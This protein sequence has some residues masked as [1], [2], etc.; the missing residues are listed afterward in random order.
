MR[1]ERALVFAVGLARSAA[2]AFAA[3][4]C[5]VA[6]F[7]Q[8]PQASLQTID[9]RSA[10]GAVA[11]DGSQLTVGDQRASIEDV[12]SLRVDEA[13]LE[14]RKAA[15][16]CVWLR[17]GS[18]LPCTRIDGFVAEGKPP[19]LRIESASGC[20]I[21]AP[22]SSV[23]ALRSRANEPQTFATDRAAPDENLDYLYVVKGGEPQRFSV[24]V[25]SVRDG[26]L[27]FDLRGSEYEFS[28][29]GD[30]SVAAVVFGK[31]TGFAPDR[32]AGARVQVELIGGELLGGSLLAIEGGSLRLR[33]F[34]G[35]E[36]TATLTRVRS[37]SVASDK[38]AWLSTMQPKAEQTA[39]F[40]RVAPWTTDRSPAGPGIR[41]GGIA[42]ARGFVLVP[43][44]K[45][46]FDLG[47]QY[48]TFE[49]M[50]GLDERSG[51][52]A[53]AIFR[54]YADGKLLWEATQ[55]GA[56]APPHALRL[57]I[58]GC[59]ELAIE[60]DFGERFD[61]GDLC[62]FADARVMKAIGASK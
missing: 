56:N 6:A 46:T 11:F 28:M 29:H 24:L 52:V 9:G 34:E 55:A 18:I 31:N 43:R 19:M 23:A 50:A 21:E 15:S 45:L 41:I 27:R 58:S 39:A 17:S 10:H 38:L 48:E 25:D 12:L 62:A 5:H 61:L 36:V 30:D 35:S 2:F 37:V 7:A 1:E 57:S 26:A 32:S 44:T 8:A 53:H 51:P 42:Y 13:A 47:G 22:V 16:Y 40:D 49:C 3:I 14:A 60:A 4:G 20:V 59:R 54:V 33:L